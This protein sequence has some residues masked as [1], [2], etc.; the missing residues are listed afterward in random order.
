MPILLNLQTM[1]FIQEEDVYRTLI[2]TICSEYDYT[3]KQECFSN[4]HFTVNHSQKSMDKSKITY[5]V[6]GKGDFVLDILSQIKEKGNVIGWDKTGAEKY[7]G[8]LPSN[9]NRKSSY[10]I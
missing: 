6:I 8:L 7:C 1:K 9:Y 4:N 3:C 2:P 5:K 10:R